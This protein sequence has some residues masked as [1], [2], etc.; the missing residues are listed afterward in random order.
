[1]ELKIYW[2]EFSENELRN[3]F[4]YYVEK[5]GYRTAKKLTDGI[6]NETLKLRN[7]PEIEQVEEL[8]KER[9][10]VF[11]YLVYKNHKI[12]Y[13]IND[14]EKWIEIADVFDT[15]QNPSKIRRSK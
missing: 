5:A 11:R 7:H 1:M 4:E 9:K 6:Y 8:L 14:K 2:T 3:I 12:I 13:R 10:E 15:R